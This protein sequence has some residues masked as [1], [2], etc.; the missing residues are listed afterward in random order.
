MNNHN[1]LYKIPPDEDNS[2]ENCHAIC[3][4]HMT[5]LDQSESIK[6]NIDHVT[7][8]VNRTDQS[9]AM[10][11]CTLCSCLDEVINDIIS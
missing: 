7:H 1:S 4:G 3:L 2:V 9:E 10:Q 5:F 6:T 8:K 11:F